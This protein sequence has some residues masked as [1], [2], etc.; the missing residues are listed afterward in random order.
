MRVRDAFTLDNLAKRWQVKVDTVRDWLA[1][2]RRAGRGPTLAQAITKRVWIEREKA[3]RT[4]TLL[5][6]D[7]AS[8]IEV[9]YV[10]R[11]FMRRARGASNGG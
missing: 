5:R 11:A 3:F 2:E 8:K 10:Y 6:E 7:Y 4:C 9:R 1:Q